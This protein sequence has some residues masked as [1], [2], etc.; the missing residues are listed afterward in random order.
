MAHSIPKASWSR[1]DA[2][3][4]TA[5]AGAFTLELATRDPR[6]EA[7]YQ[8]WYQAQDRILQALVRRGI[9]ASSIRRALADG[10]QRLVG[11]TQQCVRNDVKLPEAWCGSVAVWLTDLFKARTHNRFHPNDQRMFSVPVRHLADVQGKMPAFDAQDI[12]VR[13]QWVYRHHFKVPEPDSVHELA[14]QSRC[15]RSV[16]QNGLKQGW[17]LLDLAARGAVLTPPEKV[18]PP[19]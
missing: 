8:A 6:V 1:A 12:Q 13:V 18:G 15:G 10:Q 19:S 17:A 2:K 5:A 7:F 11:V 14:R 9:D 16:V 3:R 4:L